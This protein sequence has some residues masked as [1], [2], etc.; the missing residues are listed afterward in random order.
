MAAN[1]C[2]GMTVFIG[3]IPYTMAESEILALCP[4]RDDICRVYFP[5]SPSGS[6]R[7]YGF[8]SYPTVELCQVAIDRLHLSP[9]RGRQLISRFAHPH[10][11]DYSPPPMRPHRFDFDR[12]PPRFD[13][14][15][16]P[17][18]SYPRPPPGYDFDYGPRFY[19][20]QLSD[21][22]LLILARG[23]R[24]EPRPR[25]EIDLSALSTE[26]LRRILEMR[27]PIPPPPPA[28]PV[29]SVLQSIAKGD[30]KPVYFE[31]KD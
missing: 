28:D 30:K 12:P 9:V 31:D 13:P 10:E 11:S 19:R 6:L 14:F 18:R 21:L 16:P 3:N 25:P 15:D 17:F 20:P 24:P 5:R 22:E 1:V 27:P 4:N 26:E 2:D 29:P 23:L 8:V 7:G